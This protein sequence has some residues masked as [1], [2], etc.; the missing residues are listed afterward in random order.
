M[1]RVFRERFLKQGYN[2]IALFSIKYFWLI[3]AAFYGLVQQDTEDNFWLVCLLLLSLRYLV[4][5]LDSLHFAKTTTDIIVNA[6]TKKM[7]IQSLRTG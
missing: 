1:T 2:K 6:T 5:F 3:S 4:T 7:A